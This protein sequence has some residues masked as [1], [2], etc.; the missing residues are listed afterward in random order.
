MHLT[1][2]ASTALTSAA[3]ATAQ[4]P[5]GYGW[6][7]GNQGYGGS[8]AAAAACANIDHNFHYANT[9]VNFATHIPAGTNVTLPSAG[10]V[11][12]CAT[13]YQVAPVDLCRIAM[14]VKTSPISN[15]TLEAWLPTNWTGRFLST[16]NGGL[17]GCIQYTD[18]AYGTSL[19]F[20]TV[21][22][23]NGHNG[24]SGQAFYMNTEIVADFAYRSLHTGVVVGKAITEVFYGRNYAKSYY[25]GCSTGGRE[26]FKEVQDFP[27]DFD[28]VV[29]GAPAVAFNNLSSWSGS[30]LLKTGPTNSPTWLNP[31]EWALVH[32]DILSQCDA[33]DGVA[34]GIIEDP[35]LCNYYP[36]TLQ[37]SPGVNSTSCLSAAKVGTVRSI[38]EPYYGA[39]GTLV[40]PRMQPG[41]ELSDAF[42]YYTGQPFP[43]TTDWY[44]YAILNSTTWQASDLNADYAALAHRI[45]PYNI[46]TWNG[47]LSAY[48]NRGGKILH[49]HG[50]ADSIITS[51]NSPRY[52][53]HVSETM[54]LPPKDLDAFYRFFRIAGMDHCA[55]GV[56]AWEIGQT[57]AGSAGVEAV[58]QN[59][60][61]LRMVDWV[62]KG[63]APETVTG[64]KFVNDTVSLGVDFV[65]NHCKFPLRNQ[66]VDPANYKKPEA[67]KKP[68]SQQYADDRRRGDLY[69]SHPLT[70][71]NGAVNVSARKVLFVVSGGDLR[72]ERLVARHKPAGFED[73]DQSSKFVYIV[74]NLDKIFAIFTIASATMQ[75]GSTTDTMVSNISTTTSDDADISPE[76]APPVEQLPLSTI[77]LQI[78][79]ATTP[80]GILGTAVDATE[81]EIRDAYRA[82]ALRIHPDKAPS[83]SVREL[84]T[85]LFQKLRE[86]CDTLLQ[87][88]G[89][90]HDSDEG[91]RSAKSR[92]LP[93]T[94]E[95][96]HARNLDFREALRK[97]RSRAL[98]N[99]FAADHA[100]KIHLVRTEAKNER[101]KEKREER[102]KVAQGKKES[103]ESRVLSERRNAE[104]KGRKQNEKKAM[105]TSEQARQEEAVL[106]EGIRDSSTKVDMSW[107]EE[108]EAYQA[109]IE[110]RRVGEASKKSNPTPPKP[111]TPPQSKPTSATAKAKWDPAIDEQLV[112]NSEIQGRWVKALLGSGRRGAGTLSLSEKKRREN[113]AAARS[114]QY[115]LR[116]AEEADAV[117]R[118]ALAAKANNKTFSGLGQ[119][120]L[121]AEAFVGVETKEDVRFEK[122]LRLVD[123]DVVEM[124]L[125]GSDGLTALER[126]MGLLE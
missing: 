16:G 71:L 39:N 120:A 85:S 35:D 60:V 86:A 40:F 113:N 12:Q 7:N 19:G 27:G 112:S 89:A 68:A 83:D 59:N 31:A 67:W 84:H 64:T 82:L 98:A 34:D 118:P 92:R 79:H 116:L 94:E 17:G 99:K 11:A 77:Y 24:T 48:K 90:A 122:T 63:N 22:A 88:P 46:E 28:G 33:L 91:H 9:T 42:I 102:A 108:E 105:P 44:R 15:I 87:E 72:T 45:N 70:A 5:S 111:K 100:Q 14:L 123:R 2:L 49:Y 78:E 43:Y 101:L 114:Q 115:T 1:V 8:H 97:E 110:A 4:A 36:E 38:F 61:L 66:C 58:P 21:G 53:G 65:R 121:M 69:I 3:L 119:D 29:V 51:T 41:S 76:Q 106:K 126:S 47:D 26:G 93:E 75:S 73:K 20:A 54:G 13:P 25:L 55:G 109:E 57:S 62:E 10:T 81:A 95:S 23:N 124:Y 103:H 30:F 104:G 117:I 18:I 32:T 107:E 50:Q 37:C 6:A 125:V 80:S 52:Y 56:G 74:R 96:L